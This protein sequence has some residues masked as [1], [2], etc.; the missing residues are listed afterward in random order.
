MVISA[1]ELQT[2]RATDG[3]VNEDSLMVDLTDGRSISVP[4]L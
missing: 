4:L 2:L 1:T 3:S